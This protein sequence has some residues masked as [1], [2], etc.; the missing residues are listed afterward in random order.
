MAHRGGRLSWNQRDETEHE[1][2]SMAQGTRQ[3][4]IHRHLGILVSVRWSNYVTAKQGKE[5]YICK[6]RVLGQ[7]GP[8]LAG[9]EVDSPRRYRADFRPRFIPARRLSRH[10]KR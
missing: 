8:F 7:S 6:A 5:Y 2:S 3:N 1:S 9:A 4:A 10:F